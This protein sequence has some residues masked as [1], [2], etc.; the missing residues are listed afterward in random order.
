MKLYN[1]DDLTSIAE[2]N[3]QERQNNVQEAFKIVDQE[4]IIIER[5]VKEISVSEIV[6]NL[7]SQIEKNRQRELAKALTMIGE[8]DERQRK[9][10][11]NL[12]GIL[13]KQ[14]FLPVVENFRRAAANDEKELIKVAAKLFEIKQ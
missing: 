4:L 6:S 2:Q 13:L 10:I 1:I 5:A 9:I 11:N 14:T 12:T 8:L 7:L 3:K